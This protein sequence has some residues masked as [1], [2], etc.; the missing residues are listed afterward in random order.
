MIICAVLNRVCTQDDIYCDPVLC[1]NGKNVHIGCNNTGEFALTCP[2]DKAMVPLT[3]YERG[4]ILDTH[5]DLRNNIANGSVPGFPGAVSMQKLVRHYFKI[6]FWQIKFSK[7]RLQIWD[8]ELASLAALNVKQCTMAHDPCR[9]TPGYKYV[10]QNL[11]YRSK[12]GG[13]G[14]FEEL[15]K[16]ITAGINMWYKELQYS[17][18]S[19]IDSCCGDTRFTKIGHFLQ[20]MQDKAVYVGCAI[21]RYTSGVWRTLLMCCNYSAPNM[22]T[23]PVY[24]SGVPASQCTSTDT[25]YTSLCVN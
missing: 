23:K 14:N 10:G 6:G 9:N 13:S 18:S 4:V 3:S 17:I 22:K 21:S 8:S 16:Y 12:T 25:K 5:N 7:I 11:V 20:M 1:S 19:D 24:V 2:D 15:S